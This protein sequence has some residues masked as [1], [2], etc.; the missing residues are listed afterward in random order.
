MKKKKNE[1]Q[2][3]P[4]KPNVMCIRVPGIWVILLILGMSL[5]SCSSA[6]NRI[7]VRIEI[8]DPH[9]VSLE[10]YTKIVY[11]DLV[12][13]S[14]PKNF[15]P[16]K[17]IREF[18][19]DDLSKTVKKNIELWDND[20][21]SEEKDKM[22]P[23]TLLITGTLK[24]EI[25]ERSK[26]EDTKDNTGKKKKTFVNIQNWNMKLSI[27]IKNVSEGKDFLNESFEEKFANGEQANT[28]II[29]D[30]LFF[31]ISNQLL[32]KLTIAK[33]PERRYLLL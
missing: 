15:N 4:S 33:K 1:P 30:N 12:L 8:P 32:S 2:C 18:F 26:I 16:E 10:N 23:G 20:K 7:E 25:K 29:F 19:L 21:H 28:K 9:G 6:G 14:M 31:K 5:V 11:K 27:V 22:P 3:K 24:V 13:D 17:S